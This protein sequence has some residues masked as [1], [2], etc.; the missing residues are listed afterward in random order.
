MHGQPH[1]RFIFHQSTFTCFWHIYSPSSGVTHYIY[2]YNNCYLLLFLV[3]CLLS[4]LCW[5]PSRITDSQL[6][7]TISNS[8]IYIYTYIRCTSW[9]WT[10]NMPETCK[11]GL[12]KYNEDKRC[13]KLVFLTRIYLRF[14]KRVSV[15]HNGTFWTSSCR[16]SVLLQSSTLDCY[17]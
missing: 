9:L 4:W 14:R 11:G 1:I 10:T 5:N 12:M 6:K 15:N 7:R 16:T 3:D 17:V 13:I 8:Y 2:I